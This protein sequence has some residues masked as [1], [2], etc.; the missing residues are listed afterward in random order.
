LAKEIWQTK[1]T[2]LV[3]RTPSQLLRL[4]ASPLGEAYLTSELSGCLMATS[5][6][7]NLV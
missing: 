2:G 5:P 3:S 4:L 6:Y 7:P 1:A